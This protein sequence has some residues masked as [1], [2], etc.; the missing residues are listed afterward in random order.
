MIGNKT[1]TYQC[2]DQTKPPHESTSQ[3]SD[4]NIGPVTYMLR[5]VSFDRKTKMDLCT[6]RNYFL[7]EKKSFRRALKIGT[8][9]FAESEM[10][11]ASYGNKQR[12]KRRWRLKN[13]K[14]LL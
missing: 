5:I 2:G 6:Q 7:Q 1:M 4:R 12:T 13:S 14:K 11:A 8:R 9:Q 10:I 3:S